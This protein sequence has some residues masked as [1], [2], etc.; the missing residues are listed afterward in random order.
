VSFIRVEAGTNL[1]G[2]QPVSLKCIREVAKYCKDEQILSVFDA[3]LICDNLYFLKLRDPLCKTKTLKEITNEIGSLFDIVYFSARKL[4]CA[5][6]GCITTSNREHYE[7]MREFVPM[8]E[9]FLTYGGMSVREMEMIATGLY[10][11]LDLGVAGST[12][13]QVEVLVNEF[14]R[15]GIPCVLPTGGVGAHLDANEFMD[16][17]PQNHY[18]AGALAASMFIASGVRGMERGTLSEERDENGNEQISNMELLRLAVP[19]RVFSLSHLKYVIDRV[20][21]LYD[22]RKLVGGLKFVEEPKVLRFFFGRLE[23]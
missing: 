19:K 2:G 13:E 6:G 21:W 16:H 14:V 23:P 7:K 11:A 5:R 10:E 12:A 3:S 20:C 9:G 17:L 15:L 8:F 22:N 4:G 1:I 18:R